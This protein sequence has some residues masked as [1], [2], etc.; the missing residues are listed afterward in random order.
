[1][2]LVLKALSIGILV[3]LPLLWEDLCD[4]ARK[5]K[6][7]FSQK[8]RTATAPGGF[9]RKHVLVSSRYSVN[10]DAQPWGHQVPQC[11]F[12]SSCIHDRGGTESP[13]GHMAPGSR[14]FCLNSSPGLR[15]ISCTG[16]SACG[17]EQA[18]LNYSHGGKSSSSLSLTRISDPAGRELWVHLQRS[19]GHTAILP[20]S[21][22]V[23]QM[24]DSYISPFRAIG[25][26]IVYMAW[27][28]DR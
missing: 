8:T 13:L 22:T 6:D 23:W 19:A 20:A 21:M 25:R 7:L 24:P 18:T 3:I 1:M 9:W 26:Y 27:K 15:P 28:L 4:S 10:R 5:G 12:P 14:T 17:K 11:L 2:C 16:L